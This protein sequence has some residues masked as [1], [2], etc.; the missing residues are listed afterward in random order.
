[1]SA[2]FGRRGSP[3]VPGED[4][5]KRRALAGRGFHLEARIEQLAQTLHDR[6]PDALTSGLTGA[7]RLGLRS[8]GRLPWRRRLGML[9]LGSRFEHGM[10]EWCS[11]R[12]RLKA[13]TGIL[14][15]Q[16]P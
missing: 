14:H 5:A 11:G 1:M 10:L 12:L 4:D 7:I 3:L 2:P 9:R 6:E 15:A 16:E 8:E 13:R